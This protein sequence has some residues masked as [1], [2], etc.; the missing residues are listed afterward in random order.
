MAAGFV[1][2]EEEGLVPNEDEER[3][4][5]SQFLS[6]DAQLMLAENH[7]LGSL[8]G[9]LSSP[10]FQGQDQDL[11]SISTWAATGTAEEGSCQRPS[12]GWPETARDHVPDIA[13]AEALD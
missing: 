8:D 6:R 2:Q 7:A 11:P 13:R 9:R 4:A 10:W 3:L 1:G 5:T 12:E